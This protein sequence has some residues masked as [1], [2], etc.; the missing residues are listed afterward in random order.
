M[1]SLKV[2]IDSPLFYTDTELSATDMNILRNNAEAIKTASYRAAYI[3]QIHRGINQVNNSGYIWRGGFQYRIGLENARFKIWTKQVS[4][5]GEHDIVVF[6]DGVEVYRYA[7]IDTVLNVGGFTIFDVAID[8]KDYVD[9]QIITVTIIPERTSGT[10]GEQDASKGEQYVFDA[11]TYPWEAVGNVTWP[12]LPT[13]GSLSAANLN[14]VS[15]ALD[16]VATRVGQMPYPL[17]MN[18]FK[19]VGTNN[20]KYTKFRWFKV[21]LSNQNR[22]FYTRLYFM[23]E[24][25]ETTVKVTIGGVVTTYGPYDKGDRVSIPVAID[26]IAAGLSYD[27]DYLGTIE[28][29]IADGHYED[30]SD[31]R[32]GYVFGRIS[33]YP[34]YL[35]PSV[36]SGYTMPD[37]P[38]TSEILESLSF[39]NLKA[40]LNAIADVVDTAYTNV[41]TYTPVFN[42]GYMFR[43]RYGINDEQNE[44][45]DTTFVA[46]KTREGDVL[47]VKGQDLKIGWGPIT[48]EPKDKD[49]VNGTWTF[50]CLNEESLTESDT[51][52]QNYFY[53]DQF[54]GLYPGMTYYIYGKDIHY[55]AETLR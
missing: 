16:Y 11:F 55:A 46:G 45:F 7:A 29:A 35:G 49:K 25:D 26:L 20:P 22:W 15:N 48:T 5:M 41:I 51:I 28:I 31:G 39:L 24:N 30:S 13:F 36:A 14:M 34:M 12:G 54:E 8:D 43:G 18:M 21:R 2:F 32:G 4:G 40:R 42:R 1:S 33:S 53:L 50:K 38:E 44:Y 52:S 6:F 37:T 47:W 27:T 10:G 9:Y 23:C 3:H 17:D 19:W